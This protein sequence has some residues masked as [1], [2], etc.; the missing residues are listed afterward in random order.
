MTLPSEDE[1]SQ[2]TRDIL[3]NS[4]LDAI[5]FKIVMQILQ[6]KY[7]SEIV[8]KR[9][10]VKEKVRKYLDEVQTQSQE[11]GD[12]KREVNAKGGDDKDKVLN[13]EVDKKGNKDEKDENKEVEEKHEEEE[14]EGEEE[15]EMKIEVQ[16]VN[17]EKP[18]ESSH[19][20]KK[21]TQQ[22]T[23]QDMEVSDLSKENIEVQKL[24]L[25]SFKYGTRSSRRASTGSTRARNVKEKTNK[26]KKSEDGEEEEEGEGVE[27]KKQK[28]SKSRTKPKILS[29]G[30]A[31]VVGESL[32]TR[33]NVV[34]KLHE[35]IK[36]HC[37]KDPKNGRQIILDEK[38]QH[39][40]KKKKTDLFKMNQLLSHHLTDPGELM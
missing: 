24:L 5:T 25:E 17:K 30:L 40:F 9:E 21:D 36:E 6:H 32:M 39:V 38:L 11:N 31:E 1:L 12:V 18:K 27:K 19:K 26:R 20:S 34:K 2:A 35:Y 37:Q 3:S 7:G 13:N 16:K 23:Q 33:P 29:P 15:K 14:E 4:D 22:T 28:K 10:F 8:E